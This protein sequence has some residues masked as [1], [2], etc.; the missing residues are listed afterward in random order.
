MI[1]PFYD[2]LEIRHWV[3]SMSAVEATRL[4][5]LIVEYHREEE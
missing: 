4:E 5:N 1:V 3:K 2:W